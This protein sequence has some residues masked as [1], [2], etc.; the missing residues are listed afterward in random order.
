MEPTPEVDREVDRYRR[1]LLAAGATGAAAGLAGWSPA[2]LAQAGGAKPLPAFASFKDAGRLIVHSASGIETRREAFGTSGI[3]DTDILFVRNNI[4]PPPASIT[5]DPDAW[6]IEIQ[7]VTR[8]RT[9]SVAELKRIGHTLKPL[10]IVQPEGP[11]FA[12]A[13]WAVRWQKGN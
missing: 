2:S 3:T 4:A 6:Q 12:V 13:G 11:S 9:L 1:R 10:E 5:A 8:P 7:G